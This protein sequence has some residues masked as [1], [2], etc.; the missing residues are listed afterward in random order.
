M[1]VLI[2]VTK[3]KIMKQIFLIAS[4]LVLTCAANATDDN[5]LAKRYLFWVWN[6]TMPDFL[7]SQNPT[8]KAIVELKFKKAMENVQKS[9]I[10]LG[11]AVVTN[12]YSI[13]VIGSSKR[14]LLVVY[15]AGADQWDDVVLYLEKDKIADIGDV[16]NSFTMNSK[17]AGRN[18]TYKDNLPIIFDKNAI[19][20]LAVLKEVKTLIR[21]ANN[22]RVDSLC[23]M[24]LYTGGDTLKR[25]NRK[26]ACNPAI[27]K[28]KIYCKAVLGDLS[29]SISDPDDFTVQYLKLKDK[30]VDIKIICNRTKNVKEFDFSIVNGK[31]LLSN[32]Y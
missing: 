25:K 7:V 29:R 3:V 18:Y 17:I 32:I 10:N 19:T 22:N 6:R 20:S 1:V 4:F 2:F 12:V 14:V 9:G 11:T 21:L 15:K 24:V 31:L 5:E 23:K 30:G 8:E 16:E 27:P 28:D 13:D 26:E